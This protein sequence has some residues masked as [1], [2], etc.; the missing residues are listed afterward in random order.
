MPLSLVIE[1][2]PDG[3]HI[4]LYCGD[5]PADAEAVYN[6]AITD[7]TKDHIMLI[8]NFSPTINWYPSTVERERLETIERKKV[9]D[10]KATSE[11]VAAVSSE[12]S[13]LKDRMD[14]ALAKLGALLPK[15]VEAAQP[16]PAQEPAAPATDAVAV[17]T[18][19]VA[20]ITPDPDP[21]PE[22]QSEK[23]SKRAKK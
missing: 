10:L 21:E 13:G 7:V 18:E 11:A 19:A 22:A 1:K 23:P 14:A 12:I 16:E 15:P 20:V 6:K 9:R 5:N 17:S 3:T 8:R 4:P 2:N